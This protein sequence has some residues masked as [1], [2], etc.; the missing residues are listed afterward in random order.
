MHG[1]HPERDV[2][3]DRPP[4][5]P[6]RAV[7]ELEASWSRDVD[8]PAREGRRLI[9]EVLGTLLLAMVGTGGVHSVTLSS[10]AAA[11]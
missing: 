9:S 3:A 1:E 6:A 2:S 7:L 5:G 10:A 8:D 11:R 4:A